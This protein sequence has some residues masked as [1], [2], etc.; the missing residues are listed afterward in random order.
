MTRAVTL[1]AEVDNKE[2]LLKPGMS[3][4]IALEAPPRQVLM[5]DEEAL[6]QEGSRRFVFVVKENDT[7]EQRSIETGIRQEGKVE[8]VG[9]L[10]TGEQIVIEGVQKIRPDSRVTVLAGANRR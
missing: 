3:L 4:E 7:V 1:K 5:I 2:G 10:N 9:G 6:L 8:V